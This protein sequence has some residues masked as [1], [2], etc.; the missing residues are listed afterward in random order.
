[1]RPV[2]GILMGERYQLTERI[3]I[4]GMGE[5]WKAS[6]QVLGRT[7]AI[8]I[9]KEEYTGDE[10]FLRRFRAEARHTA[11]LNHPGI[12]DI[13]DYGEQSGSGYLVM[14]LVPGRPL[15][16]LLETD[17]TLSWEKTLSILAQTGRALQVAHDQGLVHRDVKPGN[18]LITPTRRVKITDFGIAR[19]ADQVPLTATGQV[20]GTVQYLSPE[21]ATGQ[22][23]TGSSDIYA[24][25][26]IGYE[27]LAGHRPFT[28]ESQIAIA[29]KQVNEP[30]PALPETVPEPVR[31]LIMSMLDK[32]PGKR[33]LTATKLAEAADALLRHD[34][35]SALKAV[36]AM[37]AHMDGAESDQDATTTI[38]RADTAATAVVPAGSQAP[39]ARTPEQPAAAA[40]HTAQYG[41]A[42]AATGAAH[43][44]PG[45]DTDGSEAEAAAEQRR[46]HGGRRWYWPL[47][48]LLVL[49]LLALLGSWLF[50]QFGGSGGEDEP[51]PTPT[52][53]ET[54]TP[55]TEM[56][57]INES[58][59]LGLPVEEATA[60]LQEAGLEVQ[61]EPVA[62]DQSAGVVTGV[63]PA[64]SIPVGST[65][66]VFYSAVA[67]DTLPED[68]DQA[69]GQDDES[70]EQDQQGDTGQQNGDGQP[71]GAQSP[72][73]SAAP[74]G[75]G[76]QDQQEPEQDTSPTPTPAPT[77]SP[78][79]SPETQGE[80]E[81]PSATQPE[82]TA[83]EAVEDEAPQDGQAGG[84]PGAETTGDPDRAGF[85]A[86]DG[87]GSETG[88][89][90]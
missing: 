40:E 3:A 48:A 57:E 35:D 67:N 28:G 14:E 45:A 79:P 32:D 76:Q 47:I 72:T 84:E 26:I 70:P 53:T 54:F 50:P 65:V 87:S 52:V 29:L 56:V 66:T 58:D 24:L 75:T 5:V 36:P 69:P 1:M 30:P 7:V 20:M 9:L 44:R 81:D 4:G 16:V 61:S 74:T 42:P 85:S 39:S 34:T 43:L 18:L 41:A 88:T 80:A 23:A 90:I 60:A 89:E 64:G 83:P 13:Y 62:S 82:P 38:P 11:L 21:Q 78:S 55:G 22:H 15:S 10:A 59:F 73:E 2:V 25:G 19:L 33:P 49:V 46:L 17:K 63:A 27:A 31:A 8:K 37:A 51:S 6:D 86:E 12:A 71:D 68:Q 77:P